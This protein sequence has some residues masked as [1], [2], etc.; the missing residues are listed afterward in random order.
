MNISWIFSK[1]CRVL[2]VGYLVNSVPYQQLS[3]TALHHREQNT[4]DRYALMIP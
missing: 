4:Y 2:N 3:Y 1:F